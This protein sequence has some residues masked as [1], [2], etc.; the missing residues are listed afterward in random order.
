MTRWHFLEGLRGE[1]RWYRT[2]EEGRITDQSH[3][4]FVEMHACMNDAGR[5]GFSGYAYRVH[6]K[7]ALAQFPRDGDRRSQLRGADAPSRRRS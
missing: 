2:D 5:A 7:S 3:E 1:W 4:C 6:A